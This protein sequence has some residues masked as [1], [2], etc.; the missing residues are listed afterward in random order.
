[1]LRMEI[2]ISEGS[3]TDLSMKSKRALLL[4][5]IGCLCG[6]QSIFSQSEHALRYPAALPYAFSNFVWWTDGELRTELK[7]RIPSLGD[8]LTPDSVTEATIRSVL[9]SFLKAKG[10]QAEVQSIEPSLFALQGERA[11]GAPTPSIVYS[12]LSP[13]ILVHRVT[14]QNPPAEGISG[15]SDVAKRMEGKPYSTRTSWMD[16]AAMEDALHEGG[17]L[18][19]KVTLQHGPP[20]R[21]SDGSGYSVPV[22]AIIDAGVRYRVS[23]ISADGGPLLGGRD[24]SQ[25]FGLRPGDVAQPEA[26]GR[27]IGSLR[28]LYWRAGYE[29]V[30]F[31]QDPILDRTKGLASYHLSVIPGAVYHLRSL[32]VENL[33]PEQE[34]QARAALGMRPGDI[35]DGYAVAMLNHRLPKSLAGYDCS[36][37]PKEDKREHIIDLTLHFYRK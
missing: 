3:I 29:D 26:F 23:S 9:A 8:T 30:A 2:R 20:I 28:V 25:Y 19:G 34:K 24:L 33:A 21:V 17:Y 32:T 1:M 6:L 15:L 11:P 37:S 10:V 13:K 7:H 31:R 5:V 36:W 12:I 4:I 27:L 16:I 22:E 14:L 18:Q 35:Y